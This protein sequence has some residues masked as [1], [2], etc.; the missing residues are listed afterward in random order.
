M[1]SGISINIIRNHIAC[2]SDQHIRQGNFLLLRKELP[3]Y[4]PLRKKLGEAKCSTVSQSMSSCRERGNRRLVM[5][6]WCLFI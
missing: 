6:E 1:Y 3:P 5:V 2:F 4:G